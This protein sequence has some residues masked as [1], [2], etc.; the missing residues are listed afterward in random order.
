MD[1]IKSRAPQSFPEIAG[2]LF[3]GN[4]MGNFEI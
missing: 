4:V 2:F 3:V 1:I